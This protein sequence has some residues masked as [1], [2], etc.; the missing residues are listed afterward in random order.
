MS[1]LWVE[2]HRPRSV[3]EMKGQ[4]AV[5]DRL[6]AYSESKTFPHLMFAGPP[7]TGKS[8]TSSRII[9][10]LI[11]SNYRIAIVCHSHK[12]IINLIKSI[13]DFAVESKVNFKGIYKSSSGKI[14]HQF[15]NIQIGDTNKVNVKDYQ[16]VAGTTWA[17]SNSNHRINSKEDKNFDYILVYRFLDQADIL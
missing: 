13:D 14:D 15:S 2:R 4:R 17:L 3:S 16:L 7:G 11:E 6:S 10:D 1:E 8:F 5:V 12:A 9:L